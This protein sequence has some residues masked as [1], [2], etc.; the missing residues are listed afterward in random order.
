MKRNRRFFCVI[1]IVAFLCG[2]AGLRTAPAG[3]E[4]LPISQEDLTLKDNPASPGAKAM[5]LYRENRINAEAGTEDE[6]LRKKIFTSDGVKDS[7]VS[8]AFTS[9]IRIESVRARTIRPDGSIANFDGKVFEKT[10]LRTNGSKY[11]VK[12]FS[13]P[14]VQP[15]CITEYRYMRVYDTK[16]YWSEEWTI[17]GDSFMRLGRFSIL[18]SSSSGAPKRLYYREFGLPENVKPVIKPNGAYELEIH[19]LPGIEKEDL[20]PPEQALR[21][22]V[23]FFYRDISAGIDENADAFWKRMGK[24][25]SGEVEAFVNKRGVLESEVARATGASDSPDV[26]LQKLFARAREIRNLSYESAKN[27]EEKKEENIK[28][29]ANVEDVLKHGY[30]TG[31]DINWLFVG[32]ARAAGFSASVVYLAPRSET[33]FAPEIQDAHQLTA[34]AVWVRAGDTEIY[35][36]PGSKFQ[37]YGTLPWG[38]T[39]SR[40]V[41]IGKS[42]A[43]FV[44]TSTPAPSEATIVRTAEV[45]LSEDGA[46]TGKLQVD[47]TGYRAAAWRR[48]NRDEDEA[49]RRKKLGEAVE[50]WLPPGSTFEVTMVSNWEKVGEPVHVEGTF[51]IPVLGSAIGSRMLVPASIFR[52]PYAKTFAPT[53]RVNLVYF[54]FPFEDADDLKFRAPKGFKVE[55][56]PVTKKLNPGAVYYEIASTEEG[57]AVE[58]KRHLVVRNLVVP[59]DKYTALRAFFLGVKANDEAQIVLQNLQSASK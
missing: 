36:D 5:I 11:L 47:F 8:I 54:H 15:G 48:E 2:V 13:F 22:R 31:R 32:L 50:A 28:P 17:S 18:P 1:A 38:E 12:S 59:V 49:G 43:E 23:S 53:K 57:D 45:D 6:Y 58:V 26:K 3:D 19:D 44:A 20:M 27:K 51:K 34:D 42:G 24:K 9:N 35:L 4:W 39:A 25:W 55:T 33:E 14:D 29:N 21:V 46:A 41:R 56:T 52:S 30:G 7:D 37:P 10:A 16:Y 40:G